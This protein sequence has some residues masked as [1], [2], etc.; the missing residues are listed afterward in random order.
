MGLPCAGR[1]CELAGWD[2]R[3]RAADTEALRES[4]PHR[5][6]GEG[7]VGGSL[8]Q[9]VPAP[10]W[11]LSPPT[12]WWSS[13]ANLQH[14][15]DAIPELLRGL[16]Q[17]AD[18]VL[19]SR[20]RPGGSYPRRW[21]IARRFLSEVG[22]FLSRVLLFFPLKTFWQVT[23]PTTG[24]KATRVDDRFRRLDFESFLSKGFGYKL[25]MLFRLV[26]AGAR[27]REV[28]LQFRLREAGESKTG[29]PGSLGRTQDLHDPSASR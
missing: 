17:G 8:L 23:D 26:Q 24:L 25:E 5:R 27:V 15:P 14:P 9:G 6:T 28:P 20:R 12:R 16:D 29:G 11:T 2:C 4:S 7:G 1:G 10:P 18:L 22:G 3:S 13:T 19:G 21:S